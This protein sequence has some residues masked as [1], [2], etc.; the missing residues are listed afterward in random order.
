MKF[1]LIICTYMRPEPLC[2]LL[3]SVVLQS[4][5]PDEILIIDGSTND[6]S[7]RALTA[8]QYNNL[9]YYKV[10]DEDRGLTRQRNYGID[11]LGE[12]IT[13]VCFL[14]DDIVLTPDYFERLLETYSTYP[15]ALGVGGYI[16][17]EVN[18]QKVESGSRL[19]INRFQF[20]G[21]AR[22]DGSRFVLRKRLGLDSNVPPG[23]M[24]KFSHGRSV[25]FLPPSGKIYQV[26][27]FMG[28]VSSFARHALQLQSFSTYFE[29]YG[30]YEDADFTLRLSKKG[31]LYVNTAARLYHYHEASG[32]PNLFRYGKMVV[33]NGW[34]V[35]KV[36][37]PEIDFGNRLKWNVI[38]FLLTLIRLSNTL[39]GP[40]RKAALMEALGRTAGWISLILN[41]PRTR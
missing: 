21:W 5:Y 16:I 19:P 27:Q 1:S 13:H 11:R 38:S 15:D 7:E 36:R 25:S 34:Y 8:K 20:D 29:G 9:R 17:N 22:K 30:L 10:P 28:G 18:W 31:N 39:T 40:N 41:K 6:L 35:W 32:R 33:R 14:D 37:Y 3:D 24:P 12:E 4:R 23:F 26:E 2:K